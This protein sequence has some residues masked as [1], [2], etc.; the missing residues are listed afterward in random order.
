MQKS[1]GQQR[2][3][4]KGVVTSR[5]VVDVAVKVTVWQ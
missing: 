5:E 3:A 4:G 1:N 2:R